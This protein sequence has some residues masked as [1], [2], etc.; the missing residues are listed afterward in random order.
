MDPW[1][2]AHVHKMPRLQPLLHCN[3]QV[4]LDT[5]KPIHK[6]LFLEA[7][8]LM[9]FI[10][11]TKKITLQQYCFKVLRFISITYKKHYLFWTPFSLCPVGPNSSCIILL[12]Y[13][14]NCKRQHVASSSSSL[15]TKISL[16]NALYHIRHQ[17]LAVIIW[18]IWSPQS[19]LKT[20]QGRWTY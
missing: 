8:G 19:F 20:F 4:L 1:G 2:R 17:S 18:I 10:N 3:T 16:R 12:C 6:W 11:K 9:T 7:C 5:H 15:W 13:L 14:I